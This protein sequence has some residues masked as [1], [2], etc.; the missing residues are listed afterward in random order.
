MSQDDQSAEIIDSRK[1][2]EAILGSPMDMFSYSS[3]N[4]KPETVDIVEAAGFEGALTTDGRVVE[5]GVNLLNWD[6]SESAIGREMN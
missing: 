3:G 2:L 4:Y 5:V 6:A 1:K